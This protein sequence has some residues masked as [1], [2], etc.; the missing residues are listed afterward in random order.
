M[1]F[2]SPPPG[3]TL[4][5]VVVPSCRSRTKMSDRPF[6]SPA[7]KS[8]ASESNATKR[9]SALTE[10]TT[11]WS[12]PCISALPT[13]TRVVVAGSGGDRPSA[14]A[15]RGTAPEAR[16]FVTR[17]RRDGADDTAAS[18][19]RRCRRLLGS[20]RYRLRLDRLALLNRARPASDALMRAHPT[21]GGRTSRADF[22]DT[23]A[24]NINN[25]RT[26][27]CTSM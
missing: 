6:E 25:L 17:L 10:G 1:P 20:R 23:P 24:A 21:S 19:A 11:L 26:C 27:A 14:D 4:T 3:G 18:A 5:R 13:L 2:A 8:V 15:L 22:V 7:A 9:P 16:R 12:L